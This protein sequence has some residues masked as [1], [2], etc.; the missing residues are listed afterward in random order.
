MVDG[1]GYL[2][3]PRISKVYV[4]GLKNWIENIDEKIYWILKRPMIDITIS[5]YKPIDVYGEKYFN[6]GLYTLPGQGI[7]R[8]IY[9]SNEINLTK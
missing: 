9:E 6:P 1:D 7:L 8:K 3:L 2:L 4:E 5:K